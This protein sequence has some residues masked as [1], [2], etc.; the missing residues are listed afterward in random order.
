MWLPLLL[1]L[2]APGLTPEAPSSTGALSVTVLDRAG[3]M[4]PD[5]RPEEV[6]LTEDGVAREIARVE[7]DARPLALALL[8][9]GSDYWGKSFLRELAD[10]ALD[11]L[12]ALPA[13]TD[14]ML[15]T[16]GTP[17]E[18]MD[19]ADLAQARAALKA[20]PP[21]GKLSLYDGLAEACRLLAAKPGTRRIVVVALSD[22]TTEEDRQKALEA[23]GRA[24]PQV[25]AVQF[26]SGQFAIGLDSIVQ[27]S[28]GRY[29][30][31]GAPSG[32]GKTLARLRPEL[33]APWLVMYRTAPST[34]KR[35]LEVKVARKGTKVRW[36]SPG[37]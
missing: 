24:F 31:I 29:E 22:R 16:I 9:D 17:P 32:L 1:T 19:L 34:A 7:R 33:E 20:K 4:V 6:T 18:R 21:A 14:R 37:I 36:R 2:A 28:G 23:A 15:M 25:Y 8:V 35:K 3:N 30:Q 10:P 5:L 11:F 27:W 26:Q 12:E 13:D